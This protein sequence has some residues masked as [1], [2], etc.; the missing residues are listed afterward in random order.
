MS[1]WTRLVRRR[2]F[3]EGGSLTLLRAE[4]SEGQP[5]TRTNLGPLNAKY[6]RLPDVASERSRERPATKFGVKSAESGQPPCTLHS[7]LRTAAAG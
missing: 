2:P 6:L 3:D 5:D 1:A 4:A 7:K